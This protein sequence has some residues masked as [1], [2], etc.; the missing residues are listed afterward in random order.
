M[1]ESN[2]VEWFKKS[3]CSVCKNPSCRKSTPGV[4]VT[5][6]DSSILLPCIFSM[7]LMVQIEH[8][9]IKQYRKEKQ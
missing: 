3:Y 4:Y 2:P 8:S 5:H 9:S 1:R 7:L 6:E